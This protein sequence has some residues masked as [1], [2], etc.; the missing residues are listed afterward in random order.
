MNEWNK[1][2]NKQIHKWTNEQIRIE[3]LNK[4]TNEQM[5]KWTNEQMNKWTYEIKINKNKN[6]QMIK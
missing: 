5:N 4:W 6:E 2:E 1:N 3:R